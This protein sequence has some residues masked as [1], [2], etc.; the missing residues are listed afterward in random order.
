MLRVVPPDAR[1]PLALA[2]RLIPLDDAFPAA[3]DFAQDAKLT[4]DGRAL[5]TRWSGVVHV[6]SPDGGVQSARLPA[7]DGALYYT[8]VLTRGD[9]CATRCA[10]V[11]VVCAPAPH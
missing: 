5:V 3:L 6:V 8:G 9:V 1:G 7:H 11:E 10:G 4:A 2:G